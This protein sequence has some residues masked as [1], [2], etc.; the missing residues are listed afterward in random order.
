MKTPDASRKWLLC[1]LLALAT[2]LA[3]WPVLRCGFVDLDDPLYVTENYQVQA[4][5]SGKGLAWAFTTGHAANW[6][7]LTWL[8]HQLDAQLF[9]LRAWGHHLTSLLLHTVNAILLFL[10]LR[11][12]AGSTNREEGE[13]GFEPQTAL[14]ALVAALFA[15][16]PAH[17]ESVAWVAERKDVLSGFFFML[18]LGAYV[19]YA[20][21]RRKMGAE[22]TGLGGAGLANEDERLTK[23]VGGRFHLPAIAFYLLALGFFALG[24]MSKPMLV[25]VPFV[26]LLVDYWPL[27][28]WGKEEAELAARG[29]QGR[30]SA[31][32]PAPSALRPL[33]LLLREKLPFFVLAAA[34]SV[35]T[36]LVQHAGGATVSM[37]ELS[38]GGRAANALV[39]YVRYLGKLVWPADLAVYYP[40][41]EQ[42][43]AGRVWGAAL[44][45][46]VITVLAMRMWARRRYVAMGWFWFLGMLVPVIG[47]VQ[48]GEQAMADRYTYLPYIGLFIMLAW[49]GEALARRSKY[50]TAFLGAAALGALAVLLVVTRQQ[51]RHWRTTET[52]FRQ[53]IAVTRDNPLAQE[54]LGNALLEAG[55]LDGAEQLGREALRLQP[56]F[57]EA[58]LLCANVLARRGQL[59]EASRR[60]GEILRRNPRDA[61]AHLSLAQVLSQSGE[62]ARAVEHYREGLRRRPD[63][64]EALN[65]LAWILATDPDANIRKGGEAVQFAKRACELTRYQRPLLLGTLAAAYAEA[66]HFDAAVATAREAIARAR[67]LG[68]SGLA[69]KNQ[70]LLERYQAHQPYHEP[71]RP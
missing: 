63:H 42:W 37:A 20:E 35:A 59:E 25:T 17:V 49:G 18:T 22:R 44:V 30:K 28:R 33:L 15:L 61:N 29:R 58:E 1:L 2:W 39:A 60:F 62:S 5:L 36:C 16:H 46:A 52:L 64:P 13:A 32:P 53:A 12:A 7:P 4:G 43:A 23:G 68:Q 31:P 66:G 6:H 69:E 45:L 65:N 34:S 57:V 47:L 38:L 56:G 71:A 27:R 9:G 54:C 11:R 48:V 67:A 26:L 3:Y 40:R 50:G 21:S 51:T 70:Q 10:V 19:R 14:C 41:P 8:S 24:L 55:D